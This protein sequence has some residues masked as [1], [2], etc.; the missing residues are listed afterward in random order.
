M[1][2]TFFC[3]NPLSSGTCTVFEW[4]KRVQLVQKL[5]LVLIIAA[6][7]SGIATYGAIT[8]SSNPFGPDPRTVVRLVLTDLVL[9]LALMVIICRK[10][11]KLWLERRRG[12]VGSHLQ[13]RI[14]LMF[15]LVSVVPTI[16]VAVFSA[17]F[18]N[19][20]IQ[21][22][23]DQRVT[24]ALTESVAVAEAY[25]KEHK[26]LIS[27]D[28]WAMSAELN[29]N[30]RMYATNPHLYQQLLSKEARE[31]YLAD[32]VVFQSNKILAKTSLSFSLAFERLPMD[33][34]KKAA[35]GNVVVL[36]DDD[37]E[38]VR[39]LVKLDGFS[40]PYSVEQQDTF[41]LVGRF[42]DSK[43]IDHLEKTRGAATEYK[44]LQEGISDT[45]IKFSIV[46]VVVAL[47]LLLVA[48]WVGII[49]AVTIAR[50]ITEMV[51]ATQR[52]KEGDFDVRVDE[53]PK[54]DE[55]GTLTRAFNRMTE[56][57]GRQR[58][59]LITA[60]HQID[61]RR[62]FIETVLAGVSAGVI[63]LDSRKQMTVG[64]RSALKLL[65]VKSTDLYK[66][67]FAEIFPEL[68]EMLE[69]AAHKPHKAVEGQVNITRDK[70]KLTLL[71]RIAA[72]SLEDAVEGYIVTF[73]DIS[74]LLSAQRRAAWSDVARRIAHEIKN[75][76]TPIHL[77]A[78][79]LKRKYSKDV[80]DQE[81]F[82]KYVETII[83]HVGSIGEMVEEFSSFARMP[84]PVF[85]NYDLN[86]IVRDVVFSRQCL[87][88]GIH[89]SL[90]LPEG[91]QEFYCDEG[92]IIR[93]LT[94]LLKN[95]EE[96]FE[97]QTENPK[98]W[99]T[100]HVSLSQD[101]D[102]YSIVIQDNGPGFPDHLI[103]RLTEPYVTTRNK[104]TG[105]G[106]AIVKKI[107]EDH[108]GTLRLE[109]SDMGAKVSIT[110]MLR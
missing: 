3:Q 91:V 67:N 107:I 31:R 71:V 8:Q 41:L 20:G 98:E 44:R 29:R 22:W 40:S 47:L 82:K 76:L 28:V 109:N 49:F 56:Q 108:N 5:T 33:A 57:L 93:A 24:T 2:S 15:S 92:Q 7:A 42:V 17:L 74:D 102:H 39:A 97:A 36:T 18:F 65:S 72:E 73:D 12:S 100:I 84:A 99:A 25:L 104:G 6:I 63:A 26:N 96:A 55:I 30:S 13:T 61:A 23:F 95:A 88:H 79:R 66:K 37:D 48:A 86:T 80:S 32:A 38:L 60:N 9:V 50:P 4:A 43:V 54:Q 106:L 52:I 68:T 103:D 69:E 21:S 53:G 58:D 87:E 90:S 45:Q 46:F 89:Y 81:T 94:N 101:K 77:A 64:N 83:R 19:Y 35:Q 27:A 75:P 1:K 14:V 78:E 59:E 10:L 110:F 62:H 34:L 85:E 105:L 70:K 11:V 51:N 16:I